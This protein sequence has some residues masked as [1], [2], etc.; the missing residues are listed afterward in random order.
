MIGIMD[1]VELLLDSG[2]RTV[3]LLRDPTLARR[4]RHVS[5]LPKWTVA[6]LA[7]HLARSVFNLQRAAQRPPRSDGQSLDVIAYYTVNEPAPADSVIGERIRQRGDEEANDGPTELAKR[8]RQSIPDLE[9]QHWRG[10]LA[11]IVSL[12]GSPMPLA[13]CAKACL[14]EL[15]VHADDLAASVDAPVPTFDDDALALVT[16]TLVQLSVRRHGALPVVRAF[17]RPERAPT[18]ITVF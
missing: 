15:V 14:L 12:F 10:D 5:V 2:A 6:G 8:F 9:N 3:P 11:P 1:C 18:D 13:E 17:A 4:W 16:G 7:G